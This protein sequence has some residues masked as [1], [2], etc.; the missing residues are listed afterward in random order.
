M[1]LMTRV[2]PRTAVDGTSAIQL[3]LSLPPPL[4]P[5]R[6]YTP[7][8]PKRSF[9]PKRTGCTIFAPFLGSGVSYFCR[10]RAVVGVSRIGGNENE[11]ALDSCTP[12]PLLLSARPREVSLS[13]VAP[14]EK[15]F[16]PVL[17]Y[18]V[19]VPLCLAHLGARLFVF[20]SWMQTT[21]SSE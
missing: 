11:V 15:Q 8:Y 2:S 16:S 1:L 10:R 17:C 5:S 12:I 21:C 6:H 18:V 20:R 3:L 7:V 14:R 4:L 9:L 19:W 13:L